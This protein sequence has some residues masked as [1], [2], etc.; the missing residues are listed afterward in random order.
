MGQARTRRRPV[1][2][3]LFAGVGGLSLGFEQAG[4]DV[5]AAVEYDPVHAAVHK[6][7]FPLTEVICRDVRNISAADVRRAAA[8]GWRLHRRSGP[9]WDGL[10]DV[11]VGGPSCQGFSTMGRRDREDERNDLLLEFVR[12]VIEIRPRA[13]CL[14]NVPGLLEARY[15]P[16]RESA[17][18]QLEAAGY[19]ITGDVK[20]V[21]AANFGVPQNRKRVVIMGVLDGKVD[22]LVGRAESVSVGE[23]LSMLPDASAIVDLVENDS[24]SAVSAPVV[25]WVPGASRYARVMAGLEVDP[26]DRSRPRCWDRSVLTNSRLTLHSE[27]TKRRFSQTLPGTVE[28]VS[29]FFRLPLDGQARTLRAGTGRERGAFTSPRPLHPVRDRVITV[30]EAAR[31]HSFPDWFR[32]HVTSWHGHRQI[33]NSVPPLLARAAGDAISAALGAGPSRVKKELPLGDPRLLSLSMAE[34][35]KHFDA[36]ISELPAQRTRRSASQTV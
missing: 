13:F 2:V 25:D 12:L 28:P 34:A 33:G 23:A 36:D 21:N 26:G 18:K 20:P 32:F 17:L 16:L 4:F 8:R 14:E 22:E 10:V 15:A 1:A 5:L 24:V 11:I 6:F 29:R 7:N 30:R 19:L 31:I 35:A 27:E 9:A 3:D